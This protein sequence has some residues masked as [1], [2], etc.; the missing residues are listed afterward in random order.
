LLDA[1]AA[2]TPNP[3]DSALSS[4]SKFLYV[5]NSTVGQVAIFRAGGVRLTPLGS[6]SGLPASI[7]GIAA[8]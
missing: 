1:V 4:D 8:R 3:I 2:A 6:V 5:L 7:Q